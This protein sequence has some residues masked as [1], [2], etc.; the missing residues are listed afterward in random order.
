MKGQKV[1]GGLQIWSER[2]HGQIHDQE[3]K[4]NADGAQ[5]GFAANHTKA[6]INHSPCFV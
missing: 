6:S 1:T 2:H 4:E 5:Q 3:N